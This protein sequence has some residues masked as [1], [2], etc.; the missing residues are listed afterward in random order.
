MLTLKKMYTYFSYQNL[1]FLVR[2]WVCLPYICFSDITVPPKVAF[3]GVFLYSILVKPKGTERI[4]WENIK[5][6]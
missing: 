6:T 1:F 2:E 3:G 5:V 4:D